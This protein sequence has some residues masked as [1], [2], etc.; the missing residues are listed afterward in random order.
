MAGITLSTIIIHF[1]LDYMVLFSRLLEVQCKSRE[2]ILNI[3]LLYCVGP[4]ATVKIC[5]LVAMPGACNWMDG[6]DWLEP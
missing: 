6:V 3:Y 4:K 1:P 5:P 2:S